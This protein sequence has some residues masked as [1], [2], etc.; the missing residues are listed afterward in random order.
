MYV[1][2][3]MPATP[4]GWPS[5]PHVPDGMSVYVVVLGCPW[6]KQMGQDMFYIQDEAR[7]FFSEAEEANLVCIRFN[8][9]G[10][11]LGRGCVFCGALQ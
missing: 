4:A 7:P 1:Y 10:L 9:G 11:G 3:H 5:Q 8:G 6:A 2:I